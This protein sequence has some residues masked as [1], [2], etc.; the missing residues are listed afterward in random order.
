VIANQLG[1]RGEARKGVAVE[2]IIEIWK[3]AER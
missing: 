2:K 3:E 1:Y